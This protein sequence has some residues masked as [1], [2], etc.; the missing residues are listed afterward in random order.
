[1]NLLVLTSLLQAVAAAAA[2]RVAQRREDHRP[3]A[4]FLVSMV[5]AN[6]AGMFLR[7]IGWAASVVPAE[8]LTGGPRFWSHVG[9]GL[10]LLW[11]FGMAAMFVTV[12]ARRKPWIIAA[13]YVATL[14]V[15]VTGYPMIR[16]AVLQRAYLAVELA[17]LAACLG[18]VVQWAWRWEKLRIAHAT[19]ILVLAI[20]VGTL[21]GPYRG[22]LFEDWSTAQAMYAV[23]Y[24]I[25]SVVQWGASWGSSSV[26]RSR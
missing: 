3:I 10:Y 1:V 17:A 13:A 8:P 9:Q 7:R 2:V 12:F 4:A 18:L 26:S 14:A 20:E 16:G 25:I 5:V 11:P 19:A 6:L 23:L 24:T 15:L 22:N 21:L